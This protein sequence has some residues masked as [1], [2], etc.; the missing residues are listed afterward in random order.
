MTHPRPA[1]RL[2]RAIVPAA[3]ML[4]TVLSS[5]STWAAGAFVVEDADVDHP[6][7]CK[8]ETWVS[9]AANG[10]R[11]GALNTGCVFDFGHPVEISPKF[12]RQRSSGVWE[13]DLSL[14]GKTNILPTGIGRFG[15]ALQGG[16]EFDLVSGQFSSAFINVPAT[17]Q[18]DERFKIHLNGGVNYE[19]ETD[20]Y[21]LTWGA[22]FEWKFAEPQPF[23]LI[24]E[25]F[26]QSGHSD[27]LQPGLNEP[28][29]QIGLRYSP[30]E[31]VDFDVIYGRNVTGET[32]NWITVGINVRFNAFGERSAEPATAL[33]RR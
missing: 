3:F 13:S 19:R 6:G 31:T 10:D 4:A 30:I 15:V 20:R 8:I 14:Q 7:A 25:V 18:F 17:Y 27:P 2:I 16:P 33:G 12:Q 29:A 24:G 23:T 32:S 22:A 9:A 28:R 5:E 26:G 11:I 21:W 1:S